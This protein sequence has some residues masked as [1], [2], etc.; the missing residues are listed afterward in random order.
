MGLNYLELFVPSVIALV[1]VVYVV[2]WHIRIR[3]IATVSMSVWMIALNIVHIINRT[4][5]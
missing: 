4:Y 5:G 3:N 2:P 1:A